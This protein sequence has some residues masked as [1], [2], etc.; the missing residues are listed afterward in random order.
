MVLFGLQ[1]LPGQR[2]LEQ[3]CCVTGTRRRN[4]GGEQGQWKLSGRAHHSTDKGVFRW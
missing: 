4:A 2:T 3:A 1:G